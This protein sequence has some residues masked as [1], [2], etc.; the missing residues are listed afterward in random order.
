MS[1]LLKAAKRINEKKNKSINNDAKN[2]EDN[3][4]K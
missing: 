1:R 3:A 2:Y 4:Q